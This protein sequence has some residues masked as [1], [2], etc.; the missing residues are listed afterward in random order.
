MSARFLAFLAVATLLGAYTGLHTAQLL[1]RHP[2][3]ALAATVAGVW[4]LVLWQL[5][6]RSAAFPHERAWARGL[7]WSISV[8]L[9]AWSAFLFFCAAADLS[10]LVRVPAAVGVEAAAGAALAVAALGAAQA[11]RGPRIVE[12]RVPV[13]GLPAD[14]QGLRIAQLSDL[15][16]GPTI[17]RREVE[18]V[19]ERVR[20]LR[21]DLIAVTGDL[22]DGPVRRLSADVEPLAGL[23]APLG[24][25]YV[26]GNHEYYWDARGW[27][28]KTRA[29][30]LIP[31]LNENR[32]LRR[33]EAELL[34]GGVP[35]ESAGYFIPSH[36]PDVEK[37][38]AT[39]GR[40]A[41]RILLAHRP[42]GYERAERAGFDL[43][44]SGHTHAGQF[45]PWSLVVRFFHRY[46]RGLNRHG[47]MRLYVSAGTG[48]WGPPLR[49]GAPAEIS[50]LTLARA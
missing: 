33:G 26:T 42:G 4:L 37:A 17:R 3:A 30:G 20:A 47:R 18:R 6:Y 41:V 1:P 19:V 28:E 45:F 12:V 16:V 14:L 44:L 48:F 22:V 39:S 40:P 43:Q 49:L 24:V 2:E 50:L 27:I 36:A 46:Y 21:P 25:Y 8:A 34:V 9:G 15:H 29:L 10:T 5:A 11:L 23:R 7:S 35:D 31:L 38:A 13:E 32:L